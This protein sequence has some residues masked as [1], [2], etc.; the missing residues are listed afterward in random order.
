VL[1]DKVSQQKGFPSVLNMGKG[2]W[3]MLLYIP[4]TPL[5]CDIVVFLCEGCVCCSL[6]FASIAI[7]SLKKLKLNHAY[8]Y[9]PNI[10]S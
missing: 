7:A 5:I 8:A 3:D 10:P 4:S 6:L 1:T 9:I 2:R